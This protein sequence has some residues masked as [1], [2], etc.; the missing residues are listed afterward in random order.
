[1]TRK[2]YQAF[3]E[4]MNRNRPNTADPFYQDWLIICGGMCLIFKRDNPRFDRDRFLAACEG[5]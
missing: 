3:A 1:M 4:M 5:V 2:D